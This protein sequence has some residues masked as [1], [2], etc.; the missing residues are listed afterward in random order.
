MPADFRLGI[1]SYCF[2]TFKSLDKVIDALK[3]VGLEF[4]ELWPGHLDPASERAD[5]Q[6]ALDAFRRS[7]IALEAFGQVRFG[8]DEAA[9][10]T[11]MEFCKL[12]G[13]KA[14]TADPEPEAYELTA[15]LCEEYDVNVAVHNHGRKHRYARCEA[16]DE[17]FAQT[18]PRFGLCLD[19]GW[20]LDAGED[21]LA[22]ARKYRQRLYGVHL[23]DFAYDA[24]GSNRRDVIIGTGGLDLP[25]FMK[26]LD[27][28]DYSGY[29]SLEY[30]GNADDPLD[31][32]KAC[33]AAVHDVLAAL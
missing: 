15:R 21:P 32:V 17:V 20:A 22:M 23:K 1:Q 25:A 10:R 3:A 29:L 33:V 11:A 13:V 12:A 5:L 27:D 4:L 24:D 7:G 14:V 30:E 2:R 19:T 16:L 6:A 9:S 31:D 18:P 8:T 28:M 26:L